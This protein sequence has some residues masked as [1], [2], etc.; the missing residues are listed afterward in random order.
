MS[1][2]DAYAVD[3]PH[4][5]RANFFWGEPRFEKSWL[6]TLDINLAGG[7]TKK[8]RNQQGHITPLLNIYGLQNMQNLGSNVNLDPANPLD[9]I[10]IQLSQTPQ[11]DNF[12]RLEYLGQFTTFEA[13]FNAYQNIF[14]G[15]FVQAYLPIRTLHIGA[16]NF[17][18]QS[19]IDDIFPNSTTP[20]WLEFLQN[21][22]AILARFGLTAKNSFESGIG[23]FSLLAGW[24]RNYEETCY[25]DYVD[26]DAKIGVLFPTAKRRNEDEVFSLPL[27][28]N[29]HYG[30][31]LK[32]A[33]S[34]GYWEW[35]TAGLHI[36]ALFLIEKNKTI[37]MRT[38]A[39]QNGFF[40]LA[41]GKAKVDPGTIWEIS[42]Y[43]KADHF[44]KGLS[45][46][47][48]YC[49]TQKDHDCINPVDR[50]QFNPA[51]V[52][53]D[54]QFLGWNM[55]VIHFMAEY[56]FTK[57]STDLGPRIGFF[58]NLVIGGKRIFNTG[59]SDA[60]IGIDCSW[61]Y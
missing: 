57:L 51:I 23:D 30:V 20:I 33:C 39:Q 50:N 52:N 32:F 61:E 18:D 44:A 11:R 43:I 6:S 46:L 26:V 45:L 59:I 13:I 4:F 27:G 42:S 55:H 17:I 34:L 47:V 21:F 56:D 1:I 5:Y 2:V 25:L 35:F 16:I 36:G 12:G 58:Y 49:Y 10:L 53:T 31:P 28:Y 8:A 7:T 40:N 41:L 54:Q 37:R 9:T 29:G 48:G 24:A 15:F 14:C 3:N 22:D 38:D 60:Y 19:P